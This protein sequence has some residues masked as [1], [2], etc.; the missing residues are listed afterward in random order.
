MTRATFEDAIRRAARSL[1][2]LGVKFQDRVAMWSHNQP[3]DLGCPLVRAVSVPI[4]PTYTA[5]QAAHILRDSQSEVV[6]VG[7]F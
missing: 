4:Y 1:I 5:Q 2:A 7:G 6:F 3:L